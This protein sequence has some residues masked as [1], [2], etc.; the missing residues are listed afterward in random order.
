[1]ARFFALKKSRRE[2]QTIQD[3][4][5]RGQDVKVPD[6]EVAGRNLARQRSR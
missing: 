2:Q 6:R 1:M 4:Q 3:A 5:N